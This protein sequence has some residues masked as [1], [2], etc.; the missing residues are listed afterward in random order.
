MI[1]STESNFDV[2]VKKRHILSGIDLLSNDQLFGLWTISADHS[3]EIRK[4]AY[5][6]LNKLTL[7]LSGDEIASLFFS[8]DIPVEELAER[9]SEWNNGSSYNVNSY[10]SLSYLETL[11]KEWGANTRIVFIDDLSNLKSPQDDFN[12]FY[13]RLEYLLQKWLVQS[14]KN[15]TKIIL[16]TL[17]TKEGIPQLDSFL[18]PFLSGSI[19]LAEEEEST[20]KFFYE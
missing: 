8:N 14:Y 20:N 13:A 11:S 2:K 19:I 7:S 15:K 12:E 4:I 6:V 1:N 10:F 3:W 18:S 17:L 9:F 16:G 5:K